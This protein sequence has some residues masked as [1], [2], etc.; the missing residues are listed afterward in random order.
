M[1][2]LSFR[3]WSLGVKLSVITSATVAALLLILTLALSQNSAKQLQVLTLQNMENQVDGIGDMASMFN[4]S[5]IE[6]VTNYTALFQSFLP[7][8]FSVDSSQII[9]VNS[10]QTPTLRAGLKT[11]NLD[12]TVVDDFQKRTGAISTIFVRMGDDFTSV[13]TAQLKEDGERALGTR[14]DHSNPAW[15]KMRKGEIYR[16][17]T[18]LFGKL[19]ISQYQPVAD[20]NG[21][22]I[23]VLFVGLDITKQFSLLRDKI[24]SKKLGEN[25]QFSVIG[26]AEG[27][28]RGKFIFHPTQEGKQPDWPASLQQQLLSQQQG[29]SETEDENGKT[30]I[31]C[32]SSDLI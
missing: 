7:K 11:L 19:Y 13:S 6:E 5:L 4:K 8:R 32:I 20:D 18:L 15:D 16:G 24:I 3:R 29:T 26:D 25:G 21:N 31:I 28:N 27:K 12:Q 14:M 17:V 10:E 30:Q 22:V 1:D 9:P 2:H 23:A